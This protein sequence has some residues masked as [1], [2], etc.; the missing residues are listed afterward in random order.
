MC[1]S[2]C[3][4]PL[5]L[6][7][8]CMFPLQGVN[9]YAI[10]QAD[11]EEMNE[12]ISRYV[13]IRDED[14][15][16]LKV[17]TDLLRVKGEPYLTHYIHSLRTGVLCPV[18]TE[19]MLFDPKPSAF[20]GRTHD[21]GKAFMRPEL[22]GNTGEWTE[23]D[24]DEMK[25]HVLKSFEALRG[26]FDHTAQVIIW[27]HEFQRNGYPEKMPEWL[28]DYSLANRVRIPMLGRI[29]ALVDVYD[30]LHRGNA[31]F[32]SLLSGAEIHEKMIQFNPDM[33]YQVEKLYELDIFDYYQGALAA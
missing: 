16:A 10:S 20:S 33:T 7:V 24:Y 31:K 32:G 15:E 26:R 17:F 12:E 4:E 22:L 23:A 2:L 30:A 6:E 9:L 11:L 21:V 5:R 25:E 27:H 13:G 14:R 18:V 8:I 3:K 28:H 29:L 19:R 1:L